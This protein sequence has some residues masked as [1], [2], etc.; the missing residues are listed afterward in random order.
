M[1]RCSYFIP[2]KALFGS[3]PSQEEVDLLEKEGVR[4]FID[5]TWHHESKIVPYRTRYKY[6]RYPIVDRATPKHWRSFA[7]LIVEICRV[8]RSLKDSEKVY[9]HCKG[10]HGRSGI[11]V[12]SILC[13]YYGISSDDALRRTTEFHTARPNMKEKHRKL[14]SPHRKWQKDFVHKFFEPLRM[15]TGITQGF[16]ISSPYMV[17]VGEKVYET[18]EKA[19]NEE[20]EV[21]LPKILL[22]KFQQHPDLAR[23]L[24]RTCLRPLGSDMVGVWL[25]EY[26]DELLHQ[27]FLASLAPTAAPSV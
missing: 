27:D 7:Q 5:L 25:R 1:D 20:K 18:A 26:R 3:F 11:V 13:Y 2:D 10:G 6:I 19:Y 14:G 4:H 17:K 22:L 9:I 21:S 24:L 12:A 16:P 23:K 15:G 8:I